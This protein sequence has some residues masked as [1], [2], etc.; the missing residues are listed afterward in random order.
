MTKTTGQDHRL[1]APRAGREERG[2]PVAALFVQLSIVVRLLLTASFETVLTCVQFSIQLGSFATVV[3]LILLRSQQ[4]ALP[5]PFRCCGYP[6]TPLLRPRISLWLTLFV[7]VQ[8][9]Y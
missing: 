5:R 8:H 1:L 2:V 6:I 9:P 7:A 4:P 3:G